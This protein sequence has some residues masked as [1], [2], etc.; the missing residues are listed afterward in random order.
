MAAGRHE[1]DSLGF[2]TLDSQDCF[3][4]PLPALSSFQVFCLS[5]FFLM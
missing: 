4:V 5:S 2:G 3:A 1:G